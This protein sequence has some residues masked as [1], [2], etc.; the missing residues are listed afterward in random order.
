MISRDPYE[1]LVRA[2]LIDDPRPPAPRFQPEALL[3][4]F[5]PLEDPPGPDT[6]VLGSYE[7]LPP[8]DRV[9]TVPW[10]GF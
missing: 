7:G 4:N 10:P 6:S 9:T 3:I 5:V 2:R 8:A 1:F